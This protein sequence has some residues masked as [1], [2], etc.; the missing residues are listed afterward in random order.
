[1]TPPLLAPE[2]RCPCGGQG[3]NASN[4]FQQVYFYLSLAVS[5]NLSVDHEYCF[6]WRLTGEAE[7]M[8]CRC[9]CCTSV[10]WSRPP[11]LGPPRSTIWSAGHEGTW[12]TGLVTV[13]L[14]LAVVSP[15]GW[16]GCCPVTSVHTD[17]RSLCRYKHFKCPCSSGEPSPLSG[18]GTGLAERPHCLPTCTTR[19]LSI[20]D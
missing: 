6:V 20:S 7:L 4:K 17:L 2:L 1:M 10:L 11:S 3:G 5:M 13:F 19:L 18:L 12:L 9:G 15:S 8:L 16:L 14:L